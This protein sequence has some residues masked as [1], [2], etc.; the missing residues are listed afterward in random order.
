M[1]YAVR[2][3]TR[4][5]YKPSRLQSAMELRMQPRSENT[6]RCFSFQL[7]I[8]PQPGFLLQG[9]LRQSGSSFRRSRATPAIDDHSRRPGRGENPSP[10]PQSLGSGAWDELDAMIDRED[11]WICC[12][13]A[14][15]PVPRRG[16]R[17][18]KSP[19]SSGNAAGGTLELLTTLNSRINQ[20]FFYGKAQHRGQSPVEEAIRS[21]QGV[22]QDFAPP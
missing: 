2:H 1:F 18:G 10:L 12:C 5:R 21:R 11:Y 3:F 6:Q 22:C 19:G 9:S 14:V 4:F 15:S 7:S 13:R 8:S 17:S 16:R 20:Y